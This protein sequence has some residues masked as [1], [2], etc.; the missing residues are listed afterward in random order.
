MK[1]ISLTRRTVSA[2]LTIELCCALAFSGFAIWHEA[3]SRLRALDVSIQGRSD[4][5]LGAVQDS[6]DPKD[7][8]KV[9]PTELRL[10]QE[11]LYAVYDQEGHLLGGM[12][13][14]TSPLVRRKGEG[15]RSELIAGAGAQYRILQRQALRIIDRDENG[16]VGLRRPVTIVYASPMAQTRREIIQAATFYGLLS[17]ILIST[18]TILLLLTTRQ[19]LTPLVQ[20]AAAAAA[21]DLTALRFV[22]PPATERVRELQPLTTALSGALGRLRDAI[23]AQHR[24]IGDAAHELKT[25]VAVVR[26]STQL[27]LMR[28]RSTM[29]YTD[30]LKLILKDNERVEALIGRMLTLARF[31]ERGAVGELCDFGSPVQTAA[32]KLASLAESR[33]VAVR[34]V[35]QGG[36]QTELTPEATEV[37]ASNLLLNAIQHSPEGAEVFLSIRKLDPKE[38]LLEIRD[39]GQ[40][41]AAESLPHIF[42]RFYRADASRSRDTGGTGL[43]LSICK[44][45]VDSAGGSIVVTSRPDRGTTVTV[46]FRSA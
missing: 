11:D 42:D 30:G 21:V 38:T 29:E 15:F 19:L 36:V 41:I 8:V 1:S 10:P 43:G 31:E 3:R 13:S 27:L 16:G 7:D 20:L 46:T 37:L 4:S 32:D 17:F 45:I 9:D 34:T 24:F 33:G 14:E 35:I 40:G 18:T 44:K 2:V 26:S 12:P 22:P 28:P 23:Q 6:E 39:A 5:L 25:A